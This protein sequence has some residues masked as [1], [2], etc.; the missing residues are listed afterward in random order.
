MTVGAAL[1]VLAGVV[2][3]VGGGEV[4]VRGASN[5]ASALGMSPLIVGLT[6][7]SFATS[8]PE[9]AV[10]MEAV[11]SGSP[12]LA[13]GNI[14]GSNI[15]NILLV[16]GVAAVISPLAV[17]SR[18]VKM[19][20]PVMIGLSLLVTISAFNG[21]IAQ[22]QGILL[23]LALITYVTRVIVVG[24]RHQQ[25]EAEMLVPAW[26]PA[27]NPTRRALTQSPRVVAMN[28]SLIVLCE[29][30]LVVGAQQLVDGAV[31]IAAAAGMSDVV[32]GLT[33]VAIGT[34]LPELATAIVAT[35]R[36]E[37][38]LAIGNVVGSNIFN[39]G[40]VLGLAAILSPDGIPVPV[41]AAHFDFI[42]MTA[43]AIL[44]LPIAYTGRVIARWEGILFLGYY[45]A[46]IMYLLLASAQHDAL[47]PFSAVMLIF[48]VPI[49]V[50]LLTTLVVA[51]RQDRTRAGRK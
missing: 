9:F 2:L 12:G 27:E 22:W 49:T 41:P 50:V 39:L 15:A 46:Y 5:I 51:E 35:L 38:D 44:L 30:L 42:I 6:V 3:L 29:I 19:D 21:V 37:V 45:A 18:I 1:L 26:D 28:I 10:T 7:V 31:Q 11:L 24:R 17:K 43:V 36:G 4:L 23:V 25:S 47:R 13:I 16:L 33:V 34:T 14:A 32:I 20:L 40:A 48:V 8:A